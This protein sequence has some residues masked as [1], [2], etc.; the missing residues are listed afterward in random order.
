M[1]GQ[2]RTLAAR[3]LKSVD[4]GKPEDIRKVLKVFE[5][6]FMRLEEM[7]EEEDRAKGCDRRLMLNYIGCNPRITRPPGSPTGRSSPRTDPTA[8][9]CSSSNADSAPPPLPT[10]STSSP[11]RRAVA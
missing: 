4:P 9:P 5:L 6:V 2:R 7:A 1:S 10:P 8:P 3:Y 11:N